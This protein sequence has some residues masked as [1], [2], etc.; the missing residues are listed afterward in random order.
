MIYKTFYIEN[1]FLAG[2]AIGSL[3]SLLANQLAGAIEVKNIEG[4]TVEVEAMSY[5]PLVMSYI[6]DK[7]AEFV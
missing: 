2:V 3:R 1:T 5:N 6:E 4:E 7:L